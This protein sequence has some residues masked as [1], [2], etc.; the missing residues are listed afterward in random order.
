MAFDSSNREEPKGHTQQDCEADQTNGKS[1]PSN[2]L[3]NFLPQQHQQQQQ[4]IQCDAMRCDAMQSNA[5]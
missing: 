4:Q 1:E 3:L 2:L 5:M